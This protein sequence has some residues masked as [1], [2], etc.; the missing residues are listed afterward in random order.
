MLKKIIKMALGMLILPFCLG[1]T[2]Q[3]VT[4]VFSIPYKAD[5]PYYFIAGGISYLTVHIVFR[6]PILAYVFG[7][8][9]THAL[10]AM[11]F[12]GSVKAFHATERGG[13][14]TV[15]KS[16][17]MITLA[18]YFFPLYTCIALLLYVIPGAAESRVSS[19][20]IVFA[21]GVT[22]SFHLVL[23]VVFLGADQKDIREQGALFSYP[24][25]YLFNVLF[26]A[27]LLHMLLAKTNGYIEFLGNGIIHSIRLS[28]LVL[29]RVYGLI[30][31]PG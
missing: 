12:G 27:F 23:T 20:A 3:F 24:L 1:F 21:A 10:F 28:L 4:S 13:Q 9:L 5:F 14:V 26:A 19:G 7:H 31:W 25:I 8:E 6:K 16:N 22:F 17:F 29:T 15:T 30:P 18:P 11:L 2:W